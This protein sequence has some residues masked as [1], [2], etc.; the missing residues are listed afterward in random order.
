MI[1]RSVTFLYD[2]SRTETKRSVSSG[3]RDTDRP[4]VIAGQ[5]E[6]RTMQW[7][8]YIAARQQVDEHLRDA[9]RRTAHR[10]PATERRVSFQ[11]PA[12][13]RQVLRTSSRT[14]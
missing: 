8:I 7:D 10:A 5:K 12:L 2:T 6:A 3:T 9:A 13:M 4:A 11:I 1:D 14:A